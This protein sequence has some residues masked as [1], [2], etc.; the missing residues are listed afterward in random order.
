M[1]AQKLSFQPCALMAAPILICDLPH[2]LAEKRKNKREKD[3][4]K[5]H[6]ANS[7]A[8]YQEKE[9]LKTEKKQREAERSRSPKKGKKE[10]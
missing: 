8:T 7:F 5:N 3:P 10:V 6:R 4:G 1:P 9:N 2:L